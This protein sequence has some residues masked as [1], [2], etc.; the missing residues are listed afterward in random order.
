[1][2]GASPRIDPQGPRTPATERVLIYDGQ[3]RLC[4]TAKQGLE[5][6]RSGQDQS[7]VRFVA[8]QTEEAAC[9]LGR[10]YRPGTPDVAFLVGHDGRVQYGLDAFL[11][12]LPGLPGGRLLL[13]LLRLPFARPL[14]SVLYW[15]VARYRY[16]VFGQVPYRGE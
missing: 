8:Y 7:D 1:M 4:V 6:L 2:T 5:R 16:R 11:P 10:E 14:A 12:L 13:A 3:C 9:R 15:F